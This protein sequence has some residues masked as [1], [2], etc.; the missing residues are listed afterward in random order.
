MHAHEPEG[1]RAPQRPSTSA[2]A[3]VSN[4]V[5]FSQVRCWAKGPASLDERSRRLRPSRTDDID[6]AVLRPSPIYP[7]CGDA[8]G[9]FYDSGCQVPAREHRVS[10]CSKPA[11]RR[12]VARCI[13]RRSTRRR[14]TCDCCAGT[15]GGLPKMRVGSACSSTCMSAPRKPL[16]LACDP[17]W[18][19][20]PLPGSTL[21]RGGEHVGA[22]RKAT[23]TF[24]SPQSLRC[25]L[26]YRC[27]WRDAPRA[28]SVAA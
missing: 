3:F 25:H 5:D 17:G 13:S 23:G 27:D 18:R 21:P 4:P 14:R 7:H 11:S 22:R 24:S 26:P 15:F 2:G 10:T 20:W 1:A 9:P 6:H 16:R 19:S 8:P 28:S 12:P